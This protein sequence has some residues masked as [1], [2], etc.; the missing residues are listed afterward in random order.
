[1]PQ[2]INPLP[3]GCLQVLLTSSFVERSLWALP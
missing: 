1:M 2:L 3:H